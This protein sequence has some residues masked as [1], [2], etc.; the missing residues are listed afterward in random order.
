[1]NKLLF[2]LILLSFHAFSLNSSEPI[3]IINELSKNVCEKKI[4][5]EKCYEALD[6]IISI[7]VYKGYLAGI[8]GKSLG[9]YYAF[10]SKCDETNRGIKKQ[11]NKFKNKED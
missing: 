11:L 8:C 1:M 7:S 9:R 4:D 10:G 3:Q 2:P 6:A 5:K